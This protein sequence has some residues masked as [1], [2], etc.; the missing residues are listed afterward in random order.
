MFSRVVDWSN[1]DTCI[2][3]SDGA[4]AMVL[5]ATEPSDEHR[6]VKSTHIFSDGR[7]GDKLFIPGGGSLNP[8][9]HDTLHEGMHYVRMRGN[10]LFKIAVKAM[11]DASKVALKRHNLQVEDI[12]LVIPHQANIRIME[13]IAKKLKLPMEKVMVT[14]DYYGNSSAATVPTAFDKARR[15]G[16]LQEGD[17]VLTVAFGAGVT[18]ASALIQW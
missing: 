9:S 14:I 13:G 12:D 4:G 5:E 16:K 7:H 15:V 3:F 11:V 2:L 17:T 1:R 18:W 8:T 10:E 6:V